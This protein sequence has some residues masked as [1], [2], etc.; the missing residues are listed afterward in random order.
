MI[1]VLR[2]TMRAQ[3]AIRLER[4]VIVHFIRCS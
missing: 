2:L 4:N 3:T 1:R